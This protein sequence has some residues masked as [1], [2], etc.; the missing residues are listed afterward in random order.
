MGC[1]EPLLIWSNKLPAVGDTVVADGRPL[2]DDEAEPVRI[3]L[4]VTELD[5]RRAARFAAHR[6]DGGEFSPVP[7]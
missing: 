4:R 1:E 3:E 5:G 6:V 2:D 7:D